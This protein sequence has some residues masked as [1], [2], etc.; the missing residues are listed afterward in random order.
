MKTLQKGFT[1]IELV[2]VVV[3]LGILAAV[4]IPQYYDLTTEATNSA[5]QSTEGAVRSSFAICVAEHKAN[6]TLAQLNVCSGTGANIA[7]GADANAGLYVSIDGTNYLV[8]TYTAINS[9]TGACQTATTAT[10]DTVACIGTI[11]DAS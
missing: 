8:P 4:A 2:I 10:T 5:K 6:P 1:L 9:T 11:T 7:T 3:I